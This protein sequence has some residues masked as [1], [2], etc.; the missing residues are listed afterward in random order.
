M[1]TYCST[2]YE[3]ETKRTANAYR[4]ETLEKDEEEEH[5]NILN[6]QIGKVKVLIRVNEEEKEDTA[7][8][9]TITQ[10]LN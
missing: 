3:S 4:H 6:G 9:L 1:D 2:L 5:E 10:R 8:T 7:G